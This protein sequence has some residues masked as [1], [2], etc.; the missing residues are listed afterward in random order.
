MPPSC[1]AF[2][3]AQRLARDYLAEI[4]LVGKARARLFLGGDRHPPQRAVPRQHQ[5]NREIVERWTL[6]GA[7]PATQ[8]SGD[9]LHRVGIV[10]AAAYPTHV[11]IDQRLMPEPRTPYA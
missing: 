6:L 11:R 10:A 4:A 9:F 5:R 8:A 2:P 1:C 3:A 7:T